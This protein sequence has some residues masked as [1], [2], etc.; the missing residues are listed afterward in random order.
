[1]LTQLRRAAKRNDALVRAV[2]ATYPA[3]QW[4]SNRPAVYTYVAPY[5]AEME[6]DDVRLGGRGNEPETH[7][8]RTSR[9]VDLRSA[10]VLVL[11]AGRGAELSLWER[12]RPRS[13]T[14]TDFFAFPGDWSAHA[15]TRFARM[16]VRQLG[17]AGASFDLVASTALLEH[18]DGVEDVTAEMARVTRPGGTVF[19]NFGPLFFTHAGA[20][21]EGAYEHLWMSAG[22]L[23]RYLQARAIPSEME[24]GLLWLRNGMFSRLRYDEYLAIFKRYFDLEHV[25]LGV[26][27]EA[28]RYKRTHRREWHA[29][30]ARYSE[31]DLLTF[32]MTVWMRPK[33]VRPLRIDPHAETER[34]ERISA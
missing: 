27:Q 21:F 10:D 14:A 31:R 2:R 17:F 6:F 5:L 11:G 29:L 32:S 24:D 16:D 4:L 19:A 7:L 23:E 1:M 3:I 25:T 8:A 9:M 34:A 30:T 28:L 18:V 22:E 13:L 26:S 12:Q 15:G 20:H 33:A